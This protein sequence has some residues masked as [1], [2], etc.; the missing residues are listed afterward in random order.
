MFVSKNQFATL[1]ND[2]QEHSLNHFTQPSSSM[3]IK[4]ELFPFNHFHYEIHN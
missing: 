4:E 3:H 2:K 1:L